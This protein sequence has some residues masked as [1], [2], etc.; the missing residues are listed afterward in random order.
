ML[1][2]ARFAS[3]I[4]CIARETIVNATMNPNLN[5][6]ITALV[7]QVTEQGGFITKTRLLKLLYLF[8]VEYYR[9][10]RQTFTGLNWKY[11]HLGPW[12]ADYDT[13]LNNLVVR[14]ELLRG[15]SMRVDHDTEFYRT[16]RIVSVKEALP[17]TKDEY[18]LRA[19]LNTWADKEMGEILDYVY[20]QT[21]PMINGE[22]NELLDFS[23]IPE[24]ASLTYTR[25]SSGKS[26]NEIKKLRK[27]FEERK[28]ANAENKEQAIKFTPPRY[29]EEYWKAMAILEEADS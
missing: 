29:D 28:L 12:T 11:F 10:H 18:I 22:R 23:L 24:Q 3:I 4:A 1:K 20:F 15:P 9:I 17:D 14:A 16:P 5:N 25:P 27:V 21:E 8:D 6:L 13:I 2:I 7:S 19:I 26:P